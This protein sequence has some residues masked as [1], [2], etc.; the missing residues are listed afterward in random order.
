M[1]EVDGAAEDGRDETCDVRTA[2]ESDSARIEFGRQRGL[3]FTTEHLVE[4]TEEDE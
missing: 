4:H 1:E 2:I 3:V